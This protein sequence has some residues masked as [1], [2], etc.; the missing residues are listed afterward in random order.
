MADAW[1]WVYGVIA[2]TMA[3]AGDK[4]Q[5]ERRKAAVQGTWK[6]VEESLGDDATKLFY[7][8]LFEENPAV[9]PLF[10]HADME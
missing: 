6:L 9:V 3:D 8:H 10:S 5:F 2:T 1:T 7:K 4:A